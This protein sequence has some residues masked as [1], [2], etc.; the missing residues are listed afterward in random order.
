MPAPSETRTRRSRAELKEILLAAGLEMMAS[1]T[2]PLRAEALNYKSVFDWLEE[3]Q[4]IR[5]THA[6]V[7]ERIWPNQQAFQLD[8]LRRAAEALPADTFLNDTGP[9]RV[10]LQTA[11]LDSLDGRR[12][13]I[14][15][16][17]RV[18]CNDDMATPDMTLSVY[19]AIRSTV[20]GLE[21]EGDGYEQVQETIT[22]TRASLADRYVDL[23]LVL[24]ETIGLRVRP[25][26]GVDLRTGCQWMFSQ[27][28]ALADGFCLEPLETSVVT[29]P[30]GIDGEHQEW[31]L[32]SWAV[33]CA[34]RGIVELDGDIADHERV[35]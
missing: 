20:A 27:L 31:H 18:S 25:A 30:T 34:A 29:M 8:V 19:R 17:I 32:Y 14:R 23:F 4:G 28:V 22:Q 7:H 24:A 10:V 33:W 35:L 16:V 3:S 21:P 6:S 13:A 11:D 26:L 1:Q 2:G 15:E 12:R 9:V 5:V